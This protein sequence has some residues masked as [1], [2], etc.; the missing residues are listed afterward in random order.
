MSHG[1]GTFKVLNLP[2]TTSFCR[3]GGGT[4]L[5]FSKV[6][7]RR[8]DWYSWDTLY[9]SRKKKRLANL[10]KQLNNNLNQHLWMHFYKLLN[11]LEMTLNCL[12]KV[13][14]QLFVSVTGVSVHV[15]TPIVC[16]ICIFYTSF[17]STYISSSTNVLKSLSQNHMYFCD[18][19]NF[20]A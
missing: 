1:R 17:V 15:I 16:L 20:T 13:L 10:K 19:W 12:L 11:L 9:R 18:R 2:L 3:W 4:I 5:S 6:M 14:F 7:V 8:G